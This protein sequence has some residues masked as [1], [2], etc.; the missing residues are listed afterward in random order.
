MSVSTAYGEVQE[1]WLPDSSRVV[2][3]AN[4]SL[5]YR[6]QWNH[7]DTR[8][9]WLEG[10][11]FF[12]VKKSLATAGN[13]KVNSSYIKF[14]VHTAPLK[15][16][17]V[18]TEFSVNHRHQETQVILREGKV[19]V[20]DTIEKED[21]ILNPGEMLNYTSQTMRLTHVD[22]STKTSWKEALIIFKNEPLVYVFQRLEDTYGYEVNIVD[23]DI[24][25][26]RFSGSYP[27]DSVHILL[28]KLEKLY[29]LTITKNEKIIKVSQ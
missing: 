8:E 1:F 24:L 25:S 5:R 2:L 7:A 18:G 22:A 13:Q 4:S 20:I 11:A 17:V 16:E 6:Q 23:K 21:I 10:E 27:R 19:R 26:Q 28:E 12:S 9:V 3:N 29:H 15:V 14:I